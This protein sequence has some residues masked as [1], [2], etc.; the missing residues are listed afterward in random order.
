LWPLPYLLQG[1]YRRK[2]ESNPCCR[3]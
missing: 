2:R 1:F 3:D